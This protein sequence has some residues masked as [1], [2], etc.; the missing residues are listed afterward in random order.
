MLLGCGPTATPE[1]IDHETRLAA[2][3][4]GATSFACTVYRREDMVALTF[5]FI[6]MSLDSTGTVLQRAFSI[7]NG[8]LEAM[9]VVSH[10]P[11]HMLERSYI[12]D[13]A[14]SDPPPTKGPVSTWASARSRVAYYVPAEVD[15][16]PFTT[17]DLLAAASSYELSVGLN[18]PATQ[19]PASDN[20][21]WPANPGDPP[22]VPGQYII[23]TG[24]TLGWNQVG[25]EMVLQSYT[26]IFSNDVFWRGTVRWIAR[27][28]TLPSSCATGRSEAGLRARRRPEAVLA[29]APCAPRSP[30]FPSPSSR[31]PH[32]PR[33]PPP[34]PRP[35][36]ATR[37]TRRRR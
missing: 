7:H 3:Q 28:P 27:D 5:T 36:V 11:Q 14:N 19:S 2:L 33:S 9:V 1:G 25:T 4:E 23:H 34:P 24:D 32:S 10:E 16:I 22:L 6:N 30:L 13:S 20:A 26:S 12:E 18:A 15:S 31:S 29:C 17:E 21:K 8:P 37:P 35:L